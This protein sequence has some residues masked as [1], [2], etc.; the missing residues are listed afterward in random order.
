MSKSCQNKFYYEIGVVGRKGE[1]LEEYVTDLPIVSKGSVV[2]EKFANF[3]RKLH[4]ND[5]LIIW[6]KR[7]GS[8]PNDNRPK[9]DIELPREVE[10]KY[11]R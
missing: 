7:D 8:L 3:V 4:G 1:L 9:I 10:L 5:I 6:N 11:N 2:Y